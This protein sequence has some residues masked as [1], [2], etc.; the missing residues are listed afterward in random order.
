MYYFNNKTILLLE[1][2]AATWMF[3]IRAASY[4]RYNCLCTKTKKLDKFSSH[5]GLKN[6]HHLSLKASLDETLNNDETEYPLKKI[7]FFSINQLI[8]D[9]F[10]KDENTVKSIHL[11]VWGTNGPTAKILSLLSHWQTNRPISSAMS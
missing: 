7:L 11:C 1:S 8:I 5:T 3:D 9:W 4:F 10:I 2:N 6:N